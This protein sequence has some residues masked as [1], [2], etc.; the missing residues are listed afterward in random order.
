[1]SK[2]VLIA[3][4]VIVLIAILGMVLTMKR[5]VQKGAAAR[6][7]DVTAPAKPQAPR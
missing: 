1:M 6:D 7:A 5:A 3:L 2:R 4:A